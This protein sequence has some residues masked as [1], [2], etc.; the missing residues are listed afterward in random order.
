MSKTR[1]RIHFTKQGDL[2][3]IGHRDL[4]RVWERLLRRADLQLAFSEGFHPKP[5]ISFPSALALGIEAL[6]EVVELEIV[7]EFS[8]D[9]IE[10]RIREQMP[11]G[12]QLLNLQSP[13]YK[14]GKAKV[15]SAQYSVEIDP[16]QQSELAQRIDEVLRAGMIEVERDQK[17]TI[18]CDTNS[19]YFALRL[20][21]G[22]LYFDLP[23]TDGAMLRPSELLEHLGLGDLLESGTTLVRTQVV[24]RPPESKTNKTISSR[25]ERAEAEQVA[26]V[27][28]QN[29][30]S[31]NSGDG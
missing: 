22:K 10:G 31:P 8:L 27:P 29:N 28:K 12:M 25:D 6:N 9:D 3:W 11:E 1:L 20:D 15:E 13:Q 14:L 24:L 26:S 7:G 21:D 30:A 5:R 17:K 18:T 19:E 23:V 16:A 4:A 2:R